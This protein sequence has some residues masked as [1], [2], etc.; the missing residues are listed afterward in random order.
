[1]HAP[2]RT[3]THLTAGPLPFLIA[4]H[5]VPAH[6]ELNHV[7]LMLVGPNRALEGLRFIDAR[8]G[9]RS[10]VS[11]VLISRYANLIGQTNIRRNQP[12]RFLC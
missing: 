4:P 3:L 9:N 12:A 1:V 10:Q 5:R 2:S 11:V 6:L 7:Y 8:E